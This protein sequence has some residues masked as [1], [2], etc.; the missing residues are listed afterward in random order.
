MYEEWAYITP[1]DFWIYQ[2]ITV[3]VC[4]GFGILF[5]ILLQRWYF[6]FKLKQGYSKPKVYESLQKYFK[7]KGYLFEKR[8]NF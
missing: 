5:G 1:G 7:E 4:T 8:W 6:N 2:N 3:T